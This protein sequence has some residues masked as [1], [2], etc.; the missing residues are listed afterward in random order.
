[1][2]GKN[3]FLLSISA[4]IL[5]FSQCKTSDDEEPTGPQT[6]RDLNVPA[7]FNY[8]TSHNVS[9]KVI[10]PEGVPWRTTYV[11][12]TDESNTFLK[13]MPTD[14]VE[15]SMESY[16]HI[17]TYMDHVLI[18][19]A[20]GTLCETATVPVVNGSVEHTLT[21]KK[22]DATS[23]SMEVDTDGD[24][25]IDPEDDYP[26]DS[27]RA[28]NIFYPGGENMKNKG[29]NVVIPW[30]SY[31][32]E[33]LWPGYGDYDFNDVVIDF[34]YMVVVCNT[35][36]HGQYIV[37]VHPSYKIRAIGATFENGFGM[38]MMGIPHE[39]VANIQWRYDDG[40]WSDDF[41]SLLTEGY[42]SLRDN[43][44]EDGQDDAVTIVTDNVEN[45]LP[46]PGGSSFVNTVQSAPYEPPV[47]IHL[48]IEFPWE[49][50]PFYGCSIPWYAYPW[51]TTAL[52][53]DDVNPFIIVDGERGK[54]V[55]LPDFPP[56]DL[57]N[58][59]YFGTQ[60]DDSDP[61]TGRYYKSVNNLPWAID[62]SY[63]FEYPLEKNDIIFAYPEFVGWAESGGSVNPDWYLPEHAE[64]SHVYQV[65]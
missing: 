5:L 19:Y 13:A 50:R 52:C 49:N 16:I 40:S 37:E 63:S 62:I 28:Y 35:L 42:V 46:N 56:T 26:N 9:V 43:N 3:F 32:F 25:V 55:H 14:S 29:T 44:V 15:R 1:M 27:S 18:R 24:H 47:T 30:A 6:M 36:F 11:M 38:E 21:K 34:Y 51:T 48:K 4:I 17:P 31:A 61:A 2:S 33:D 45:I 8:N 20:D 54:E 12:S 10:I 7:G 23:L 65:P 59:S 53:Y 64:E 41:S 22:F 60:N 58:M 39:H 57:V